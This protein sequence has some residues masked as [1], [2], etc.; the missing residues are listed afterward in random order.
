ME[1]D[2]Q[3]FTTQA[4]Q[5]QM[6]SYGS[7]KRARSNSGVSRASSFRTGSSARVPRPLRAPGAIIA[8]TVNHDVDLTADVRMGINFDTVNYYW[9]GTQVAVNGASD[10]A[11]V[12]DHIRVMKVEF[13]ILPSAVGLD[14][15]NQTLS[16]GQTNI[17]YVYTAI[18]YNDGSQPAAADI[19]QLGSCKSALLN[20]PIKRTLYPRIEGANGVIDM[21]SNYKNMFMKSGTT[22]SQKW[23]GF[24]LFFD[25]RSQVW[26]YGTARIVMK[27]FY[28]CKGT[29]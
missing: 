18:D 2:S 22:S 10:M 29:K 9:N 23:N 1:I 3:A 28:E 7:R 12:Y 24:K 25:M 11:N 21:S 15:T 17:P 27:I 16:T 13:T 19:I 4:S 5:S 20:K 14:Y 6:S 8:Y 26:T